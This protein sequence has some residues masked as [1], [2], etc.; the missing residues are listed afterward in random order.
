MSH[1]RGLHKKINSLYERAFRITYGDISSSFQDL[2]KNDNSVSIHHRNIEALATEM[3]KVKNNIALEI[4]KEVFVPKTSPY[5]LRNNN[6]L[7]MMMILGWVTQHMMSSTTK[8]PYKATQF[9]FKY[10]KKKVVAH[11]V[12]RWVTW[13]F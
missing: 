8:L 12:F 2:L 10:M 5:D 6:S 13:S 4:I 1:S 11:P 3:F 7:K 9:L